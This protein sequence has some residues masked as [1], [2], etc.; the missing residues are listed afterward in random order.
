[1]DKEKE[2][3]VQRSYR[4][5]GIQAMNIISMLMIAVGATVKLTDTLNFWDQVWWGKLQI[6]KK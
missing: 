4:L 2:K 5:G 1:M 6:T 3:T